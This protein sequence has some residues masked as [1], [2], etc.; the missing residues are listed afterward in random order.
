MRYSIE[1]KNHPT[2]K[3]YT[4][5]DDFSKI[6]HFYPKAVEIYG[7]ENIEIVDYSIDT[8]NELQELLT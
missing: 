7:R 6:L 1:I 8:Y 5:T 2:H 3:T 4:H